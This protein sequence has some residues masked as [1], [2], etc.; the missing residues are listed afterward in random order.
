MGVYRFRPGRIDPRTVL[1]CAPR[2]SPFS[3]LPRTNT[4]SRTGTP[5]NVP[6]NTLLLRRQLTE[7]TKHP[8][9]GFSA[10]EALCSARVCLASDKRLSHMTARSC[11]VSLHCCSTI[12][13]V[14]DNNLYEWEVMIIGYAAPCS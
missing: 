9:D 8:V 12:G 11:I 3:P 13:L 7:L 14:D 4:M 2:P 10:G 1:L 5:S 6:S